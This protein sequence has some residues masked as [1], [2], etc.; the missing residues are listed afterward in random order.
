MKPSTKPSVALQKRLMTRKRLVVISIL[1]ALVAAFVLFSSH[2]LLARWSLSAQQSTLHAEITHLR[3]L[4]DSLR[5]VIHQLKT[6]TL[7]IERLA[8]ER[9]GYVR[10]GEQIYIIKTEHEE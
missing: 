9:Y 2:G 4:E 8:R 1:A 6:D 5:T 3:Q 10:K 7:L